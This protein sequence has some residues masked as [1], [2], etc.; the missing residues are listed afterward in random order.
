MNTLASR[1]IF[2]WPERKASYLLPGFFLL[3]VAV[4]G[5]A[6]YLF[7]V[8]YPPAVTSVPP[9]AKVSVLSPENPQ[10]APLLAWIE[11]QHPA[12]ATALTPASAP[13]LEISYTPS[14]AAV[15][16]LPEPAQAPAPAVELPGGW[17]GA[18]RQTPPL[19]SS[20]PI[21]SSLRFSPTLLPRVAAPVRL[22]R[23]TAREG[24]DLL[25]S[26]FLLGVD[27][28][29]SVRYLIR[30][31][32]SGD[33]ALDRQA[34]AFLLEHPFTPLPAGG[35]REMAWGFATLVWGGDLERRPGKEGL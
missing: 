21:P 18:P 16:T 28:E 19:P 34:E 3:A 24:V 6:F 25:P 14:Y 20:A 30:Q 13:G 2:R 4:H 12:A 15:R 8:V 10:H 9:Q 35:E 33:D 32:G 23:A 17:R 5:V 29:G 31:K 26:H 22:P 1:L 11:A 27:G 7:Q